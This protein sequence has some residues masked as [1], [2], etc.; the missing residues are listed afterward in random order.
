MKKIQIWMMAAI[1][2]LCGTSICTSCSNDHEPAKSDVKY[3]GVPLVILDTDLGSS[4]SLPWR[5]STAMRTRAAA[6]CSAWW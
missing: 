5:C 1:L 6:V 2:T 3:T 4:T